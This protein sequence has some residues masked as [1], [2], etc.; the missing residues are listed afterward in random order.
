MASNQTSSY[1][2]SQWEATDAVQRLEFNSDNAK[3]DAALKSLS[4]QVVQKASQ[5]ALNTVISAVNQKADAATVSSLS[6]TVA[7]KAEQS[8]LEKEMIERMA[9]DEKLTEKAGMHLLYQMATTAVQEYIIV[10][11]SGIDWAQWATVR[12]LFKPALQGDFYMVYG[13]NS[14]Q[15]MF[16]RDV[17]TPFQLHLFPNFDETSLV[18][19]LV[20]PTYQQS[21]TILLPTI[22]FSQFS[23]LY[24]DVDNTPFQPGSIVKVWGC[25]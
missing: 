2:L 14:I 25:K 15:F 24:F 20:W 11:L 10:D 4:D 17:H 12:I 23:T 5:S 19:G 3:V 22:T 21:G 8:A 6:Q 9:A 18:A 1:G 7:G 13:N 16:G